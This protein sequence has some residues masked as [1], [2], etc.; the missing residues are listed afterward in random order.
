MRGSDP[1]AALHYM[2][3]MIDAGEQPSFIA[4]RLVICAAEDVGLADPQPWSSPMPLPRPSSSSAGRKDALS[5][6]KPS[7]TWPVRRRATAPTWLSMR[8]WPTSAIRTA[9]MCRLSARQPLQRRRRPGPWPDLPVP[10]QF[11]WGLG[12]PAVSARCFERGVLL[13]GTALWTGREHGS[14]LA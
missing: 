11:R 12:G 6:P 4:R 9:A 3:R 14:Y 2:A 10:S 5:C 7:S 8:L 1:D 13:P